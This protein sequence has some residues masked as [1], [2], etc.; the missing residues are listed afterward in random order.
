MKLAAIICRLVGHK[1]ERLS[2]TPGPKGWWYENHRCERC[3]G[4]GRTLVA[5]RE[6]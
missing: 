4:T 1:V 2:D 5:S 6:G 3:G